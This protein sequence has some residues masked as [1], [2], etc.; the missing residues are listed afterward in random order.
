MATKK[1]PAKKTPVKKPVKVATKK[2]AKAKNPAKKVVAKKATAKTKDNVFSWD[3]CADKDRE[4]AKRIFDLHE[5]K[6]FK[7]FRV[8]SKGNKG[9][10]MTEFDPQ[11]GRIVFVKAPTP[12]RYSR[13]AEEADG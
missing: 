13:I 12:T 6:N 11:A 8:T 4:M 9:E 5:G 10:R 2:T 7:A 3:P 1:K